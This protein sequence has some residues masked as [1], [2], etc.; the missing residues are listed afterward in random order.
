[1]VDS[2]SNTY[3]QVT[4][5]QCAK[6]LRDGFVPAEGDPIGHRQV[7]ALEFI[8]YAL[9]HVANRMENLDRNLQTVIELARR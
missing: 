2:N 7:K 6:M 4:R 8:A 5:D 9:G 1:M 3:Q